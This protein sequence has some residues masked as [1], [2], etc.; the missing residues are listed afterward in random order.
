MSK[1]KLTTL[2]PIHISS[3]NEF[4]LNFNALYKDGYIYLYDEFNIV[5]FFIANNIIVPQNLNNLKNIIERNRTKIIESNL[6]IRKIE[7]SFSNFNKPI[8]E[9][10]NTSYNPI[11]SGS[12][13]KGSIRTAILECLYNDDTVCNGIK[14]IMKNKNLSKDR[15]LDKKGR[16]PF[17]SD[18]ANIFRYLKI[19]DSFSTLE[20]KNYKTI[21]VKK[22]K[23]HQQAREYRT[24]EIS[25]YIEAIKPN[26]TFEIEITDISDKQI[27]KNIGII[28]NKFY[29]PFFGKDEQIYASKKGYLRD[30]VKKLSSDIFL[31]NI[32]RFSG[33]EQKSLNN[34]RE[35]K[36]VKEFDK[37]KTIAR[38]FAL[39]QS[40]KDK[41]YFENEL[42]PFGWILCEKL[43]NGISNRVDIW[44]KQI[45]RF[46]AIET[47]HKLQN[48]KIEEQ[49]ILALVK[50]KREKE[51]EEKRAKEEAKERTRLEAMTPIQ[52]LVQSYIDMA[53]LIN[54]MKNGKIEDFEIIKKELA[55]E[56][57]KILQQNPKTWDRAKQKAL[58]RKEYI[59]NILKEG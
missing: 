8:F 36:G 23:S 30:K 57:K 17:D 14:D 35:I 53:L 18:F 28:C 1:Y 12:S 54:D 2:S 40:I 37:S 26:Q 21:N 45:D 24:E 19:N 29:I 22:D 49:K 10:L 42:L 47:I 55:N 52:R 41:I 58:K 51:E 3:G 13:I 59:E 43:D 32:G 5:D 44:E 27:F 48:K 38:T 34:I 46:N 15:L 16:I 56:V 11:I 33:A 7:S 6:H 39:E 31:I 50:A 4:E 9:Q 20:T 25:N